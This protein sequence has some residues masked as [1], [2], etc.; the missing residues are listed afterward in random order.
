MLIAVVLICAGLLLA[1]ILAGA[2]T[3]PLQT[4]AESMQEVENMDFKGASMEKIPYRE[5]KALHKAFNVMTERIH[6]LMEENVEEQRQKRKSE[7]KA[8]RSQINP[9]FLY[10]T[11]DSIIWMAEGGKNK[12]VVMMTSSLARLLR[13]SISNDEEMIPLKK[14]I[15]HTKSYLTIQKMRYKDK[16]E[17]SIEVAPEL[18]NERVVNL[19][20][21]PIV[22]NAIYHG[23]KPKD[24]KGLIK[25][26]G[27]LVEDDIVL[28]VIDNGVG[29]SSEELTHI[30]D[31]SREREKEKGN[32]VGVYNVHVRLKLYYGEQ[33]GL[34]FESTEGE[35]TKVTMRLR[36]YQAIGG[37]GH[38]W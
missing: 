9:H 13:Q 11:L 24:G 2:I 32:G 33:Y 21:Q 37:D 22:E 3:K 34:T 6:Q 5:I 15:D 12:E 29:I 35:G 8:L 38:G 20:L 19:I 10:N 18:Q 31:R 36:R 23:I 28:E 7:L 1:V 25:I 4:L 26:T 14:E 16:L 30:F 17:F 27:A